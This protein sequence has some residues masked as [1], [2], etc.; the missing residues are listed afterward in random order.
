MDFL[1]GQ[2]VIYSNNEI[3][4][5]IDPPRSANSTFWSDIWIR[6]ANGVDQCV[7]RGNIKPLPNGQL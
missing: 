6:R 4:T 7:A 2:R 3:V 1:I 5:V